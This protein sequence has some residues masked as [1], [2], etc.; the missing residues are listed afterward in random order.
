ME[1]LGEALIIME[2]N[3]Q[4]LPTYTDVLRETQQE[5]FPLLSEVTTPFMGNPLA[6]MNAITDEEGTVVPCPLPDFM[7][8][9]Q[10]TI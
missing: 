2:N 4:T 9:L 6:L 7:Y 1:G 5:E 10:I 8:A 3:L